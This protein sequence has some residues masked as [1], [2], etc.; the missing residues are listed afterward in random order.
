MVLSCGGAYT[1]RLYTASQ[2]PYRNSETYEAVVMSAFVL[3]LMHQQVLLITGH[4]HE[5]LNKAIE[6]TWAFDYRDTNLIRMSKPS[7][8]Q[9]KLAQ[10]QPFNFHYGPV[11]AI[12][13]IPTL[14][15]VT[16]KVLDSYKFYCIHG[17]IWLAVA[18]TTQA[19]LGS[20]Q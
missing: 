19:T 17:T 12:E 2:D 10:Q 15:T 11:K 6:W 18:F 8:G 13:A 20:M 1:E 14:A 4:Q 16:G 7:S 9:M 3:R 5:A